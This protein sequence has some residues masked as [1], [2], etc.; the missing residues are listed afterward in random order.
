MAGAQR[1]FLIWQ[2]R[3]EELAAAEQQSAEITRLRAGLAELAAAEERGRS[4]EANQADAIAAGVAA[5]AA[6]RAAHAEE[7]SGAAHLTCP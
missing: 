1:G 3:N 4:H 7:A 6:A 2:V 5:A